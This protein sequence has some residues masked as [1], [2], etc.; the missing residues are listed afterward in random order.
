MVNPF[1]ILGKEVTD[2]TSGNLHIGDDIHAPNVD[3]AS[4]KEAL[5]EYR[6]Y[7]IKSNLLADRVGFVMSTIDKFAGILLGASATFFGVFLG[8]SRSGADEAAT[9]TADTIVRRDEYIERRGDEVAANLREADNTELAEQ[10]DAGSMDDA[11]GHEFDSLE[12]AAETGESNTLLLAGMVVLASL[13]L[14]FVSLLFKQFITR[15]LT[16][17]A[18]N[19][20]DYARRA[21]AEFMA[22]EME[23]VLDRQASKHLVCG[24]EANWEGLMDPEA[25]KA[26]EADEA[27]VH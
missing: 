25:L 20:N 14:S 23:P 26:I 13:A 19:T 6:Q 16:D 5:E 9:I 10:V 24:K 2:I 15:E 1:K 21:Q 11:L 12:A 7:S 18:A 22:Q 17:K 3:R 8:T 4:S 27:R